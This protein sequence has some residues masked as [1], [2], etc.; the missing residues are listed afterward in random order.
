M[1]DTFILAMTMFPDI[2]R[3]AQKAIDQVCH[4]RLPEYADYDAIPYIHAL[5]RECLRWRPAVPLG[6]CKHILR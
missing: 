6:N 4:G 3:E 5:V 1:L 2:Q